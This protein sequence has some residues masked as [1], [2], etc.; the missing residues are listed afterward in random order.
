MDPL[1]IAVGLASLVAAAFGGLLGLCIAFAKAEASPIDHPV[2]GT[3]VRRR[4]PIVNMLGAVFAWGFVVYVVPK[5]ALHL[6]SVGESEALGLALVVQFC[7]VFV[8][9]LLGERAWTLI[10]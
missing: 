4:N 7:V 1:F 3:L 10:E 9:L 2:L 5:I 8:F 6:L